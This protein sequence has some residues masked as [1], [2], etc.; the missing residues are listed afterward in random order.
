[1][2]RL[3]TNNRFFFIIMQKYQFYE[4]VR[5]VSSL[6]AKNE[7]LIGKIGMIVGMTPIREF[8]NGEPDF[9]EVIDYLLGIE[10]ESQLL[11]FL[12]NEIETVGEFGK[13]EDYFSDV[14]VR[15]GV[16]DKG[17]GF[18]LETELEKQ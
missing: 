7:Y 14:S 15:I 10:G 18:V 6:D 13:H 2:E 5:V 16:D 9:S 3:H 17:R 1:M 11:R 12:P 8:E 4:K